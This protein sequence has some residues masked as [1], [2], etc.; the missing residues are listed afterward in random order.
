MLD[1]ASSQ[2]QSKPAGL[3]KWLPLPTGVCWRVVCGTASD[4]GC[5]RAICVA[6]Q[7][8]GVG[9]ITV[10]SPRSTLILGPIQTVVP[11]E[12][13]KTGARGAGLVLVG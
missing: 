3:R 13:G 2:L 8:W 7:S 12:D 11:L 9:N 10:I 4:T 5:R 1:P 6:V